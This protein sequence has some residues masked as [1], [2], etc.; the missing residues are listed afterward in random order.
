MCRFLKFRNQHTGHSKVI[1]TLFYLDDQVFGYTPEFSR[2]SNFQCQLTFIVFYQFVLTCRVSSQQFGTLRVQL[3]F[4]S[5]TD[6]DLSEIILVE[7]STFQ[8]ISALKNLL[9]FQL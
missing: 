2:I 3:N 7:I 6:I 4:F 8:H 5:C 1:S 9:S